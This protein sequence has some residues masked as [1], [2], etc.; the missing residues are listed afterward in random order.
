MTISVANRNPKRTKVTSASKGISGATSKGTS[1]ASDS[2]MGM[3]HPPRQRGNGNRRGVPSSESEP[4]DSILGKEIIVVV[5][6][7]SK[8][9]SGKRRAVPSPV[10]PPAVVDPPKKRKRNNAKGQ[11][12]PSTDSPTESVL[13][14]FPLF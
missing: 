3:V 4:P 13:N 6:S 10:S 2:F 7:Q 12:G 8:R 14:I 5:D 1:C 9:S 11:P